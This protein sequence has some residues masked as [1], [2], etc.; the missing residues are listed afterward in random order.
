[1]LDRLLACTEIVR[2]PDRSD[3]ELG[4]L[5]RECVARFRNDGTIS[6]AIK[7]AE[8]DGSNSYF[9]FAFPGPSEFALK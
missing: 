1:V 3:S 9:R 4:D 5:K 8:P 2:S 7:Y 6:A